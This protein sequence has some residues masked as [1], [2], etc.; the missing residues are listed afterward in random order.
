MRPVQLC[1]CVKW[2]SFRDGWPNIF[3]E[4]VEEIGGKDGMFQNGSYILYL[5]VD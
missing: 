4:R 2:E 1:D 3:I 5:M